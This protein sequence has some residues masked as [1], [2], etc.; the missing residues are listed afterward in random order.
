VDYP[1]PQRLDVLVVDDIAASRDSLAALVGESGHGVCCAAD[2]D[3]ALARIAERPPHIVLLDLLLPGVDGFALI[4]RIREVSSDDA[5]CVIAVS[6]LQ[7]ELHFEEAV[8]RGADDYLVRPVSPALLQAKLRLHARL[9]GLRSGTQRLLALQR[10]IHD[11]IGD[12]VVTL[13][14]S[15]RVLEA[16]RAARAIFGDIPSD[17]LVGASFAAR[18]GCQGQ[19]PAEGVAELRLAAGTTLWAEIG[20][21]HWQSAGRPL[22]TLAIQ[23]VSERIR[24]ERMRSEFLATVSHELRTP[25]TSVLGA[26]SLLA[27][28]AGGE[29]TPAGQR[30]AAAAQRNGRRLNR[31]IDDILDV[32]KAEGDRLVLQACDFDLR[33]VLDEALAISADAAQAA[34]VTLAGPPASEALPAVHGDPDR[35]AQILAQLL[36]NA[37]K[38]APAGSTIELAAQAQAGHVSLSVTDTGPGVPPEYRPHLFEKFSQ[39]DGSD[40]RGTSGAGLGLYLS[41]LLARRMGT[42]IELDDAHAGGA[43]FHFRLAIAADGAAP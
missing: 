28:G 13:D 31:L 40:T 3:A 27:G 39:A 18:T 35:V 20:V 26:V 10:E 6:A 4:E 5:L 24:I 41:Q 7:G 1:L 2:A 12:A 32:T 19:V 33:P 8:R 43:R 17:P 14:A 11:H 9:F 22:A 29:L 36:S 23:D 37:I 21:S 15:G 38:H 34:R 42:R 30:L 25:L 16:N